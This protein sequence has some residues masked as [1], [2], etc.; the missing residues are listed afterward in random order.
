MHITLDFK[1]NWKSHIS[2]V[3]NKIKGS[4]GILSTLRYYI[5]LSINISFFNLYEILVW[6]YTYQATLHPL[7]ILQK[8]NDSDYYLC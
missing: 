8:K 7:V 6:G 3:E 5:N 2:F 4:I 1:L